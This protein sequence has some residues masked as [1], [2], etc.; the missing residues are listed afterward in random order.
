MM[1][2]DKQLPAQ[3]N[4]SSMTT[5]IL[6]GDISKLNDTEK[7]QYYH[8]ICSRLGVDPMTKPFDYLV[9]Q[10]KQ[11]LYLNKGGAEQ[12]N[13]VHRVSMSITDSK[14]VDDIYVVT[15]RAEVPGYAEKTGVSGSRYNDSTGAVSVKGLYGDALCNAMMK[16]ETKA[17]RR[18]T[19]GLL[20]LAML[21][22][23]EVDSIP[24]ATKREAQVDL[25]HGM[26]GEVMGEIVMGVG[27]TTTVTAADW[28]KLRD[29][30]KDNQ[31]PN[32][33]METWINGK[34]KLGWPDVDIYEEGLV[35][36]GKLNGED[37]EKVIAPDLEMR[38]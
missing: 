18:A 20:G 11:T 7:V 38:E 34:R 35:R 31:W 24:N 37:E 15:A 36:F 2:E 33:Y 10:G 19:I 21:D 27:G 22:E 4:E 23:T 32:N 30:G 17:K 8:A 1:D 16:A 3:L 12:L 13:K 26:T 25:G 28:R 6:K 9:L 5:L 14:K 29:I